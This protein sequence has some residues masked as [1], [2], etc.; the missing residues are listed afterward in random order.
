MTTQLSTRELVEARLD[1][2]DQYKQVINHPVEGMAAKGFIREEIDAAIAQCDKLI[3]FYE[4][5]LEGM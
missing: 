2:Y 5:L 1:R 3:E 4:D